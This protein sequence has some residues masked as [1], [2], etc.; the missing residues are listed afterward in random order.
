AA[1]LGVPYSISVAL[2]GGT[3]PYLQTLFAE[4]GRPGLFLGYFGNPEATRAAY[5]KD[6]FFRTGDVAVRRPGGALR[7]VGRRKEMY[8]SGG[9]NVYPREIELALE[10][11]PGV[12]IAAVVPVA[13]ETFGEVGT[14]FCETAPGHT[15]TPEE[16]DTWCRQRLANY[17]VPKQFRIVDALPLLPVGKVDKMCLRTMATGPAQS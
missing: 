8:K 5:T 9:Y 7:L 12:S 6:G 17:K 16:L 2:F 14:A 10:S 4:I 1:G 11:H 3:A 13:H 15:V